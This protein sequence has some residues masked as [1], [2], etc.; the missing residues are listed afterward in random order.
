MNDRN[1]L[2]VEEIQRIEKLIGPFQDAIDR[3]DRAAFDHVREVLARNIFHDEK[4]PV[5]F[6]KMI[7]DARQCRMF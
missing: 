3:K 6:K 4:L 1:R 7:A 5:L 2:I